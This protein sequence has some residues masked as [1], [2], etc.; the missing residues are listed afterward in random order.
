M[1]GKG[2]LILLIVGW[3]G[4]VGVLPA[5]R[6]DFEVG[7]ARVDLTRYD[8]ENY[9]DIDG[10]GFKGPDDWLLDT[11]IDRRFDYEEAGA[12]GPDGKPGRA[13]VDDDGN[14]VTDD[15]GR[16]LT[17]E[18]RWNTHCREYLA[19]GSDD[20]PDPAG[21]DYH[22]LR[23]RQGTERN[24]RYDGFGLAG[25][26]PNIVAVNY[27]AC[28][29]VNRDDLNGDGIDD[30]IWA[31][32]LALRKDGRT[33]L[34]ASLD[35]AGMFH[36]YM[37]EVKRKAALPPEEGGLGIPE[38]D[39]IMMTT[40][41]HSSPDVYGLW[42]MLNG[43]LDHDYIFGRSKEVR[44]DDDGVTDRIY[45]ALQL[46]VEDLRPAMMK[47]AQ[48]HILSCYDPETLELKKVPDCR[49]GDSEQD[50]YGAP[51]N[52]FDISIN[53]LDVRDPWVKNTLVTTLH[54][55]ERDDPT[56]TIATVVNYS[57][58]PHAM[59]SGESNWE[60]SDYPH[61]LREKIEAHFGGIAIFWLGTQGAH[62]SA[63]RNEHNPVMKYT[64]SGEPVC[65]E[66]PNRP[67]ECLEDPNGRD[68]PEFVIETSP[69]KIWSHGY[70]IADVAIESIESDPT[71]YLVDPP[72][73]NLTRRI[74]L[75]A[76]NPAQKYYLCKLWREFD[77]PDKPRFESA[78]GKT[79]RVGKVLLHCAPKLLYENCRL[80]LDD[81]QLNV[82]TIG[83]AQFWTAP[84]ETDPV[85]L[86][87]RHA[88]RVEY[89][90]EENGEMK[91]DVCNFPEV[92]GLME[93][94]TGRHNFATSMT[95]SYFSYGFPESDFLGVL[96]VNHPNH[97]EDEV[98]LGKEFG[99]T[100][101]N[102]LSE[103]LGGAPDRFTNHTPACQQI[104]ERP[105]LRDA[106]GNPLP[107]AP[108]HGCRP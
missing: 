6:A 76:T 9:T 99:D 72:L 88:S 39:I 23:N 5:A 46:A 1:K 94:M 42:D 70:Y 82:V 69:E 33:L 90:W 21:D 56:K 3:M 11:G 65:K 61:Y 26:G 44:P 93:L 48:D 58:H 105:F 36:N 8:F 2:S 52:G 74:T 7:V 85:Y 54:F 84:M 78:L 63:L 104:V 101:A 57:T 62:L 35:F 98:T 50:A 71:P 22:P 60:S 15:C 103:M 53:Q 40:H 107:P 77:P 16:P 51:G 31:R 13:G 89:H 86:L 66:D 100:V 27:R 73:E 41:T 38:D 12:F 102:N 43:G 87:G 55:V 59:G 106:Q 37:N 25:Y 68:F 24:G 30:G 81:I 20:I 75:E 47:S 97:Y 79:C 91:E 18:D 45:R 83:E 10:D 14:G 17:A 80:F 108:F 4:G 34:I 92:H 95:N 67:G 19:R 96:N 49:E 29:R 32:V 64:R 28:N